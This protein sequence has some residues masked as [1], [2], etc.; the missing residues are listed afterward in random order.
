MEGPEPLLRPC[1]Y[2]FRLVLVGD[3]PKQ[4][5]N[6]VVLRQP[7]SAIT[8]HLIEEVSDQLLHLVRLLLKLDVLRSRLFQL[9]FDILQVLRSCFQL[10]SI[11]L[12][13]VF[14]VC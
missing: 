10:V 11:P 2:G 7:P 13:R 6:G 14:E 3:H 4:G 5:L 9:R 8:M 12:L 1:L